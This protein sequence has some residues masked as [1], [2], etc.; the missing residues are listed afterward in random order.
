MLTIA[1]ITRSLCINLMLIAINNV[2]A[3]KKNNNIS[4]TILIFK[5]ILIIFIYQKTKE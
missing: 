5:L 2:I 3:K 1:I 4:L